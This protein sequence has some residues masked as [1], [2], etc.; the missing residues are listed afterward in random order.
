MDGA[1]RSKSLALTLLIH[2]VLLLLLFLL[3][4]SS[5]IP[6]FPEAGGGGG[7]MVSIG[8]MDLASGNVQSSSEITSDKPKVEE[9]KVDPAPAP[10]EKLITQEDEATAP[11]KETVNKK[12]VE[13]KPEKKPK[14]NVVVTPKKEPERQ[15]NQNA[16]FKGNNK[17]GSDGTATSGKGDQGDPNG[18]PASQFYG[19]NGNGNGKDGGEGGGQGGG[20]GP[21]IG[22]G[23]GPGVSLNLAGRRWIRP[24]KINDT[25]QESGKVV[26]AIIVDK[27]GKVI[28]AIAGDRGSTTTSAHLYKLA[29]EAALATAFN[30]SPDDKETQKG[31]ITFSFVLE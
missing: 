9:V 3:A 26:V 19:K 2:G 8:T 22:P 25:S 4:L 27:S 13:K 7:V 6:P 10:E 15:L 28:S 20:T 14:E 5:P 21:G 16:L 29:K 23:K 12:K 18:D 11:V 1:I 17:S 24:P 30:V 31:T